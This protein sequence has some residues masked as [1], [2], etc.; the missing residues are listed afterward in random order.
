MIKYKIDGHEVDKTT[1]EKFH[2]DSDV[3]QAWERVIEQQKEEINKLDVGIVFKLINGRFKVLTD[4]LLL[5][6]LIDEINKVR[7]QERRYGKLLI[8]E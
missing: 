5:F 7:E 3:R 6:K 2:P 1:F 4:N 8:F